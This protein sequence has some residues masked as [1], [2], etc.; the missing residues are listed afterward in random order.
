M[1]AAELDKQ[2]LRLKEVF[3]KQVQIYLI[4]RLQV[5]AFNPLKQRC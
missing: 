4:D 1:Q 2:I 5:H 3:N